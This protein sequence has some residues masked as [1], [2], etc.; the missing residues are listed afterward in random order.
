ME[1]IQYVGEHLLPGQIGHF[2]LITAFVSSLLATFAYFKSTNKRDIP[3]DAQ[4]WR[5]IGRVAFTLHG[6]GIFSVIGILFYLMINQYYEYQY[7]WAHVSEDLPFKYIFSAFW[8][9]QEGSFLLWMFWHV[10]LGM[11]LMFTAK[12]WEAPTLAM[13]SLVQVFLLSMVLGIYFGETKIGV[14]P[15]MLLRDTMDAPI[16]AQADYLSLVKGNGLNPLLQNYWMTIHPPTLFLGFASTTIPFVFAMAGLWTGE[17]KAWLKPA[18]PW[19]LFCGSILGTGILMGGAWAYE[20]LS[21]GGYWA[22]DP[23]EN[24]SLVPW[25]VLIAGIHTHLIAKAT[26]RAIKSTYLYYILSFVLIVYSTFLTRSGVLGETSVHAFTEMG[27]EWQLVAF[28]GV[29]TGLAVGMMVWRFRSVPSPTKEESAASKEFW[30]FIG[31]LVLL[32]S[33]II[34]TASTSLPVYNKIMTFFD[35]IFQGKVITDPIPHYNKYQLWIAVFIALLSGGAQYLRYR[36]MNWKK[37]AKKFAFSA[38]AALLITFPLT[39]LINSWTP[40]H[41]WQYMI[42]LV[43]GVFAV[44]SNLDYLIRIAKGSPKV[45]GSAFAHMGFGIMIIGIIA[46]GLNQEIISSSPFVMEGLLTNMED[47][48]GW[49]KNLLLFKGSPMLMDEYELTYVS[50]TLDRYDRTYTVNFK[51][52][53][54]LGTVLED[55]NIYPMVQ[56]TKEYDKIASSNPSTRHYWDRDIF[57]YVSGLPEVEMNFQLRRE[58]EDSL[59]YRSFATPLGQPMTIM[60]TVKVKDKD[61]VSIREYRITPLEINREP[62]NPDY[63]REEG[64]IPIGIKLAVQR[65]D[66][67]STY[68]VEPVIVLR[69]QLLY[70][71][72][73]QIDELSAKLRVG[74]NIFETLL[75]PEEELDY[76]TFEVKQGEQFTYKGYQLQFAG[77]NKNPKHVNYKAEEGDI[78]V[79]AMVGIQAPSGENYMASPVFFIRGNNPYNLKDE[80][81]AEG[82]HVR[83]IKLD[84]Q[85]ESATIWVAKSTQSMEVPFELATDSFSSNWIVLQAIEFP[86][87]NFF[88]IGSIL[89]MFGLGWSMV[90]RARTKAAAQNS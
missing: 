44:V 68:M 19:A 86:G 79:G 76:E 38:I 12:R 22:W 24:M 3:A 69:G 60:D 82:L 65:R 55:F 87:I 54:S 62:S 23:V 51:R 56:Y 72:P 29:F 31:T 73:S 53:D 28:M 59:N 8:E 13:L 14:N 10:V 45:F 1:E 78:A 85:T 41:N 47:D 33:A 52:K 26:G 34:I 20:A 88:W 16:F 40:A 48:E 84:P 75:T 2:A 6:L 35:P 58:R 66:K 81:P 9:G 4:S 32:F 67:D 7:V 63:E 36:E 71:Y 27:L 61:S 74:E 49:R 80:I 21:F 43:S 25:L 46:S 11:I 37:Y 17:H 50:D 15:L 39:L 18:M 57:T 64:D 30:M 5:K 83:F 70:T 89:M 42:L 90:V 77:F